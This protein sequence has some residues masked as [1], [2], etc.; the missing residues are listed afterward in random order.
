MLLGKSASQQPVAVAKIPGALAANDQATAE[1][2]AHTLNGVAGNLGATTVQLAAGAVEQMIRARAPAAEIDLKL[3]H[4]AGALDPLLAQLQRSLTDA[5]TPGPA[6][7]MAV[8]PA[9]SRA[10]AQRLAALLDAF[11]AQAADFAETNQPLLRPLFREADWVTFL[12]HIKAY[13][14]SDALPLLRSALP[15]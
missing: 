5:G 2:L 3:S 15:L 12:N 9:A 7:A 4:L 14:F 1:R 11:D 6:P 8:D 13:A 10:A